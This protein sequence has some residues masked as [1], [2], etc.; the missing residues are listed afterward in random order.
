MR[1]AGKGPE[2]GSD[3]GP[4]TSREPGCERDRGGLGQFLGK[5]HPE[6]MGRRNFEGW[7][8]ARLLQW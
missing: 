4:R 7:G 3:S 6:S 5:G 8:G 1:G 2:N